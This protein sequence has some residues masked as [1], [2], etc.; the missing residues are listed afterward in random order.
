[1]RRASTDTEHHY[2]VLEILLIRG[3][4]RTMRMEMGD[5]QGFALQRRN[6]INVTLTVPC[7]AI[8]PSIL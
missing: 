4:Y 7:F 5:H 6:T 1:M 3:L 2:E 8:R